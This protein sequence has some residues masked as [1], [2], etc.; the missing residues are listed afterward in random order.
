MS[1]RHAPSPLL[2]GVYV[3]I[4]S[5][6]GSGFT[7]NFPA[8]AQASAASPERGLVSLENGLEKPR[9]GHWA[10]PLPLRCPCLGT[11]AVGGAVGTRVCP[12]PGSRRPTCLHADRTLC[13][14]SPGADLKLHLQPPSPFLLCHVV[15]LSEKPGPRGLLHFPQPSVP[16][17]GVSELPTGTLGG[18]PC[19]EPT[20]RPWTLVQVQPTSWF[21]K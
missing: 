9:S 21:G 15:P 6:R 7:L 1:L 18:Q 5:H 16:L 12:S 8:P 13:A 11:S 3:L 4:F 14:H 19:Q 2:F 17:R 10:H 20:R